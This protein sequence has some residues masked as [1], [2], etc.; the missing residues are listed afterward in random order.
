MYQSEINCRTHA[1]R[2]LVQLK[3]YRQNSVTN[4]IDD[5]YIDEI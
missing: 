3:T 2:F 1:E 5:V 4:F